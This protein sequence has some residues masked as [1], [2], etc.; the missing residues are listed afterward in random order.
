MNSEDITDSY[1]DATIRLETKRKSLESYFGMLANAKTTDEVLKIQRIIDGITEEI[2]AL[3]G[4]LRM[5]SSR[6]DMA[7]VN[8]YIR[9]DNDPIQIRKEISWNTLSL[10]DMGYLIKHGFY[11]VTN[12]IVS[13]LQ[14]IV[15][16]LV[17]YSPLWLIL[18][19]AVILFFVLK[20]RRRA[21]ELKL[22][23]RKDE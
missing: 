6:V 20:K 15:V 1:Y 4:R 18:A 7:T 5:W 22:S 12:T 8:L 10:D 9:Q 14:W 17:G 21:R 3:E 2:E 16:I 13:L 19:A 23:G 11:S